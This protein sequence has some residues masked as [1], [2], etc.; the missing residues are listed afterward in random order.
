MF[1]MYYEDENGNEIYTLKKENTDGKAPISALFL[2]RGEGD[3]GL[4]YMIDHRSD[5][6]RP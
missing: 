4:R 1:P 2:I 3:V 6:N 5:T